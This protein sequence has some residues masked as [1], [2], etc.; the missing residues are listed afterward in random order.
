MAPEIKFT[1]GFNIIEMNLLSILIK[2]KKRLKVLIKFTGFDV[3]ACQ[4]QN[5]IHLLLS[6]LC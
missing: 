3:A 2:L 6:A 5:S 1:Q 4:T